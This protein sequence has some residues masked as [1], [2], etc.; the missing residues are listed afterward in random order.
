MLVI[1]L[2]VVATVNTYA[3]DNFAFLM[4]CEECVVPSMSIML[5]TGENVTDPMDPCQVYKCL[6]SHT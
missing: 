3:V 2:A 1:I 5:K 4:Q 6:V